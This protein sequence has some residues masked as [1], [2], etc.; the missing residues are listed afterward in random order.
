[1]RQ[2]SNVRN[3]PTRLALIHRAEKLL[4]EIDQ[5]NGVAQ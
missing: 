3:I 2:N 5:L 4:K 1:M